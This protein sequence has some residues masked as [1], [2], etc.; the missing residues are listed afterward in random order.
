MTFK[1]TLTPSERITQLYKTGCADRPGVSLLAFGMVSQMSHRL[2]IGEG[3]ANPIKYAKAYLHIWQLFNFDSGPIFGHYCTGN[4]EFGGTLAYPSRNSKATG[5]VILSHAITSPEEVELMEVPDPSEVGEVPRIIEACKY[6]MENYPKGYRVPHADVGTTFS[7]ATN[8]I[9]L[10]KLLVWMSFEPDLV[11]KVSR[12]IV[13][14]QDEYTRLLTNLVGPTIVFEGGFAETNDFITSMQFHDFVLPYLKDYHHKAVQNG[15]LGF[16]THPCGLQKENLDLWKGLEGTLSINFDSR[17]YLSEVVR[18][19][20][21]ETMV[22][23]NIKTGLFIENG[24]DELYSKATECLN[25]SAIRC[26]HGYA[27]GPGCEMPP[28][29]P[30][31]NLFALVQAARDFAD[32]KG[33]R[34][35]CSR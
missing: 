26:E 2:T 18:K 34:A 17:N 29:V 5:P 33:W 23:G 13:D 15:V 27:V 32:T 30:P 25:K 1:E 7:W 11:H 28:N 35:H 20:A 4:A 14:F 22:A 24:F 10:E 6:V 16:R 3:F 9:G 8:I 21:K 31:A 19:F 12:K